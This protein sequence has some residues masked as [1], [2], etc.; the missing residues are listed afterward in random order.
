MH[1]VQIHLIDSHIFYLQSGMHLLYVKDELP[2]L[3]T[4][5]LFSPELCSAKTKYCYFPVLRDLSAAFNTIKSLVDLAMTK[6]L[7]GLVIFSLLSPN[8]VSQRIFLIP[9][10]V[11]HGDASRS[12]LWLHSL[13]P[14][15]Q[16]QPPP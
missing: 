7:R 4:F 5:K 16:Y 12:S 9:T 10:P 14:D 15:S 8:W 3:I 11:F 1:C 13:F 6:H 2:A